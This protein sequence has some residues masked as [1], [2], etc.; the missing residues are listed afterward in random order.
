MKI[1]IDEANI[2]ADNR[3]HRVLEFYMVEAHE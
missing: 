2:I 1:L 3:G